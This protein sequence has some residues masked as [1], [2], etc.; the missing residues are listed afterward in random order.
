[1][2]M[3]ETEIFHAGNASLYFYRNGTG[4]LID[5]IYDGSHVG[6]SAMPEKW[7]ADMKQCKGIWQHVDGLIFT[8]RHPDH[9]HE[10]MT[11]EY[12]EMLR[13]QKKEVAVYAPDWKKSNVSFR[14]LGN[15]M[16]RIC[17]KNAEI[18]TRKTIHDGAWKSEPHESFLLKMGNE[19]FFVAGDAALLT[20][21][22][23]AFQRYAYK[24]DIAFVNLYQLGGTGGMQCVEELGADR[25]VLYHLPFHADDSCYYWVLGKQASEGFTKRYGIPVEIVE[26]M[27]WI[28][29]NDKEYRHNR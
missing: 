21:D 9:Y 12:L 7:K 1:M 24:I 2:R 29:G 10:Q 14:D 3:M 23:K 6:M 28:D 22:A 20:E 4:I 19:N 27:R 15:G 26:H 8:H 13:K 5:G 25:V 11:D 17:I 16:Q 18:I